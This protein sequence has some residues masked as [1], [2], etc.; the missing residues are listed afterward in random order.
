MGFREWVFKVENNKDI[1]TVLKIIKDHNDLPCSSPR[2]E[3]LFIGSIIKCDNTKYP[4]CYYL[5]VCNGGGEMF[6]WN[7]IDGKY[8]SEKIIGPFDKIPHYKT[9]TYTEIPKHDK[10]FISPFN[11]KKIKYS[12]PEP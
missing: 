9:N 5:N 6:V 4:T 12:N 11:E 7:F 8:P 10:Y 1:R 2:G 3:D